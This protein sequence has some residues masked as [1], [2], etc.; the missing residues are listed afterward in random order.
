[1]LKIINLAVLKL[2]IYPKG[3]NSKEML[4]SKYHILIKKLN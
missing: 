1:M 2:S 4:F 3:E